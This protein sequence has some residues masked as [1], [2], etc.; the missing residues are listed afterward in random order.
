MHL[1][2]LPE[3]AAHGMLSG[4]GLRPAFA[5]LGLVLIAIATLFSIASSSQIEQPDALLLFSCGPC[6]D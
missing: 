4:H 5:L 6:H 3:R 2:S 1:D